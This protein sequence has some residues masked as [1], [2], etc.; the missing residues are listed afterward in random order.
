MCYDSDTAGQNATRQSM[1]TLQK[2]GLDVYV[3]TLPAGKVP[4]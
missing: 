3:V 1:F 2:H 4:D